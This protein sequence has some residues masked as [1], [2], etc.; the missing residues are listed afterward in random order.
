MNKNTLK[1]EINM[2]GRL[3]FCVRKGACRKQV[4]FDDEKTAKPI[5][6]RE[7]R[8]YTIEAQGETEMRLYEIMPEWRNWQTPGT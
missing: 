5:D 8:W 3:L 2:N 7:R 4:K 1:Y 6:K